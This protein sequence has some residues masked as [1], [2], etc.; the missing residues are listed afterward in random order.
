MK[1]EK[2]FKLLV[3]IILFIVIIQLIRMYAGRFSSKQSS[4][5]LSSQPQ[6]QCN[7]NKC[8]KDETVDVASAGKCGSGGDG[9][10]SCDSLLPVLDPRFNMRE[11]CKQSVLLEDHLFQKEKRC[12]D[13]IIKHFLTIEGL[14]EEAVTLDKE[15]KYNEL[16]D[17]P[18]KIRVIEKNYIKNQNDPKQPAITAQELREIRKGYMQKCFDAFMK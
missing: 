4:S 13:C 18:Q 2:W 12:H 16:I 15:H 5:L 6:P 7:D 8:I 14:A 17:L 10:K 11:I 3:L 1:V 9:C